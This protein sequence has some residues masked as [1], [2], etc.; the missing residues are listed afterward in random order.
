VT[1]DE[2]GPKHL[3]GNDNTFC[4]PTAIFRGTE[5]RSPQHPHRMQ[6]TEAGANRV[7]PGARSPIRLTD[8]GDSQRR[9]TP[10]IRESLRYCTF[11]CGA[12]Q[13]LGPALVQLRKFLSWTRGHPS[14]RRAPQGHGPNAWRTAHSAEPPGAAWLVRQTA[15]R[16]TR[17]QLRQAVMQLSKWHRGDK[18]NLWS[19]HCQTGG[20]PCPHAADGSQPPRHHPSSESPAQ[21]SRT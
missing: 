6:N 16:Q 12:F 15:K 9:K 5:G 21:A 2:R 18:N 11:R 14:P 1:A 4:Q 13:V 8:G 10:T 19:R 7:K 17:S 20:Q 3:L